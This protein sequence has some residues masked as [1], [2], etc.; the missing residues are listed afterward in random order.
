MKYGNLYKTLIIIF[1]AAFI[2]LVGAKIFKAD[3]DES[4]TKENHPEYTIVTETSSELGKSL[5]ETSSS[6]GDVLEYTVETY[7]DDVQVLPDESISPEAYTEYSEGEAECYFTNTEVID[8]ELPLYAQGTLIAAMQA[9]INEQDITAEELCCIDG[10]AVK[11][12]DT[13][14]FQVQTETGTVIACIYDI[15]SHLWNFRK[16]ET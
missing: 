5:D 1:A 12:D 10:S 8:T 15:D 2:A 13:V 11:T 16:A 4:Q 9:W 14:A 7:P 6:A 3:P